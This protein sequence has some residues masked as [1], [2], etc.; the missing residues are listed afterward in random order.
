MMTK[1]HA[2]LRANP[3]EEPAE[4]SHQLLNRLQGFIPQSEGRALIEASL[5]WVDDFELEEETQKRVGERINEAWSEF[6]LLT[7]EERAWFYDTLL[8]TL[9]KEPFTDAAST[10]KT[11]KLAELFA[12]RKASL[13]SSYALREEL[14]FKHERVLHLL[15]GWISEGTGKDL[16]NPVYRGLSRT[17]ASL[18]E[19]YFNHPHYMDDDD[20]RSEAAE[21]L[22]NL[23]RTFYPDCNHVHIYMLG[24]HEDYAAQMAGLIDF[25]LKLDLPKEI[26]GKAY[27]SLAS[28]FIGEDAPVLE[29][30]IQP[31]LDKLAPYM[32]TWTNAQIDE[33]IETFIYY[34]LQRQPL[35][36]I[37]R[38]KDRR[39]VLELV[40]SQKRKTPQTKKAS[41]MLREAKTIIA[42][43]EA[44][45]MPSGKGG[46]KFADFNFKLAVIEELMYKQQV[47][48]PRFDIGVFVQEYALR[49]ISI[50]E[51]GDRPIPEVR[52]YFERLVL[53]KKDLSQVTKLVIGGGQQV[54]LQI[55]PFWNGE[56]GYFDVHS[57]EDLKHLPNLRVLQA[58]RLLK[59]DPA[60]AIDRSIILVQD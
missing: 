38:S 14:R 60:P 16:E 40:V 13:E 45:S 35:L 17:A 20:L 7:D 1:L 27:Y 55:I 41:E 39:E 46:V 32:E 34:P 19:I 50:A 42:Q 49:E 26:K 23:I 18:F 47:L 29:R 51:E 3:D 21:L 54:Q 57:L 9:E 52:E 53:T 44:E 48:K 56:D 11:A 37:A 36:Q 30:G 43:I 31:V 4:I 24:Y 5:E 59:A 6:A 58:I 15:G 22:P 12:M 25:Y 28:S 10:R 33:F 8:G 2:L